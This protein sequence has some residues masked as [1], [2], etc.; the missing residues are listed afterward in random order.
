MRRSILF[1]VVIGFA[2]SQQKSAQP[3]TLES[4]QK[5][6]LPV[7]TDSAAFEKVGQ[8]FQIIDTVFK[9][10][11]KKMSFPSIAYGLVI[12]DK[13]VYS[14]ATGVANVKDNRAATTKTLYRIASMSKSFTAM[15]ILKLRDEE[16]LSLMDP[17]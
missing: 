9:R 16:K 6:S 7:F 13:L 12:G 11:A 14:G 4:V 8:Y 15:A 5:Y 17:V 1:F 10:Y 2:C 3:V